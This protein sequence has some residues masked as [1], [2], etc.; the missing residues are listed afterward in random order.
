MSE[1]IELFTEW[2]NEAQELPYKEPSFMTLATATKDGVPSARVILLKGYDEQGFVFYTNLTSRKGKELRENPNA[3]LC[4]YWMELGRQIRIEG[5]VERVT[6]KEA[7]NYF[8]GRRRESQIGA[9]ASKQSSAMEHEHDFPERI[10]D[11]KDQFGEGP[12][13]RPPF[14]SGFRLLPSSIEFWQ[15]GEFRLHT[16]IRYVKNGGKWDVERLYP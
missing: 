13:P 15:E 16:R 10:K 8:A 9:W 11:I 5:Q 4:F 6:E 12:V 1:P 2:Y 14:W 3:A 7:D